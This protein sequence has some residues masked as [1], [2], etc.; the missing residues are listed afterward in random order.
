MT[1]PPGSGADL[2]ALFSSG[3]DVYGEYLAGVGQSTSVDVGA[4]ADA[5]VAL[6]D[7]PALR[8]RMGAAGRRR[9]RSHF[10]W[11]VVIAAYEALWAE[12]AAESRAGVA[13]DSAISPVP[14][15][16]ASPGTPPR[17]DPFTMFAGF[18]S[19]W[20][21][22]GD[23]LRVVAS[24]DDMRRIL[25]HRMNLFRPDLLLPALETVRLVHALRRR[26]STVGAVLAG[27]PEDAH[28]RLRRTMVW[29]VKTA[30]CR[31]V[32]AAPNGP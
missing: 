22:D 23:G 20:L 30:I 15:V 6:A 10:D 14:P 28:A 32:P 12:L 29:L 4:V 13:A 31:I 19:R 24:T 16:P 7:D 18:P 17:P 26:P 11:R 21:R 3:A 27:Y 8:A 5:F 9:A 2:A 25:G 1:P